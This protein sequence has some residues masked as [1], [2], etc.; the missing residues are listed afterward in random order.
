M[1]LAPLAVEPEDSKLKSSTTRPAALRTT[2]V[3][4]LLGPLTRAFVVPL[5][6][7]HVEHENPPYSCI[8]LSAESTCRDA[9]S[10][11]IWLSPQA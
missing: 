5:W 7:S 6:Y 11:Y 3:S 4:P 2:S 10:S 9:H 1:L 8:P